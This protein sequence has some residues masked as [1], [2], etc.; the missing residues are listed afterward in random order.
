ML[1]IYIHDERIDEASRSHEYYNDAGGES[2]AQTVLT[3]PGGCGGSTQHGSRLS[4]PTCGSQCVGGMIKQ[5]TTYTNT[6][7]EQNLSLTNRVSV[8]QPGIHAD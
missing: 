5:I 4:L 2:G 3:P 8:V 1:L 7:V 6:K